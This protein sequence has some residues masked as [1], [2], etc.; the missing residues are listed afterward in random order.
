MSF[1]YTKTIIGAKTDPYGTLLF[2][3][4][5]SDFSSYTTVLIS[6]PLR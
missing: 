4:L 2:I 1:T 3:S 5:H 6:F